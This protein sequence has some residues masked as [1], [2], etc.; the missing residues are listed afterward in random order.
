MNRELQPTLADLFMA[1]DDAERFAVA[2]LL[3]AERL[4]ALAIEIDQTN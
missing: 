3:G 1:A 2:R 4:L